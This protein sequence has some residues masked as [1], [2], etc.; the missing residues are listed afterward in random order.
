MME[1]VDFSFALSEEQEKRKKQIV[2]DLLKQPCVK[3]WQKAYALDDAFVYDHSGRFQ[4]YVIVMEK[5]AHCQGLQFCRQPVKGSRLEIS[6]DGILQN[7]LVPC[8]YQQQQQKLLAHAKWYRVCDMPQEY[9]CIDLAKLDL[10]KESNEYK[11]VVMQVLQGI[12]D[13]KNTKGLYLWGKPG[14][15]KSYLAAGMCNY[16]AKQHRAVAFVNVPKLISDLKMM[17]Q[18]PQAMEARLSSIRNVNV[19]VLDDIGGESITSWSRDDILLPI[20]DARMEKQKLT[21]FTSN[22]RMQELKEKLSQGNGKQ[23]EPMAAE[24]LLERISTLAKEIFVK[25]NSR[26]K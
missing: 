22:Y 17:F 16:F 4:D 3:K 2:A 8:S 1:P 24:R 12:M 9:L 19:L 10:A 15:G 5:C 6:Y 14:A 26:R 18:D 21:I 11:G 7:V 20:L 13:E 25:G 23:V